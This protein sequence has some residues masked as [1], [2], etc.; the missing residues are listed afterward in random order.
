[1]IN[2]VAISK[3]KEYKSEK[4]TEINKQTICFWQNLLA[5]PAIAILLL[6]SVRGM[7]IPPDQNIKK[8]KNG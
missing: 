3:L 1:M 4:G 6:F 2:H 8:N 5:I 7:T